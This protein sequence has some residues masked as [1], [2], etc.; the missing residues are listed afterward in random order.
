MLGDS[1]HHIIS[2]IIT[3]NKTYVNYYDAQTNQ[4]SKSVCVFNLF[5]STAIQR[6]KTNIGKNFGRGIL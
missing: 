4:E 5:L 1:G 2:K 3:E 6:R